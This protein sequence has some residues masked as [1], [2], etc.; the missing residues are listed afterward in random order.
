MIL[1]QLR[2]A[3]SAARERRN[4]ACAANKADVHRL[5]CAR[6]NLPYIQALGGQREWQNLG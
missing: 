1:P 5:N 4:T 2:R 3:G 6:R